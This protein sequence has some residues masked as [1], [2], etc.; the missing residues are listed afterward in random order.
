MCKCFLW[1]IKRVAQV[2]MQ[3][4]SLPTLSLYLPCTVIILRFILKAYDN[5]NLTT[6]IIA[7]G[8]MFVIFGLIC[9]LCSF[10]DNP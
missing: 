9:G 5:R 4:L 2:Y 10:I 3:F 1:L 7:C 6:G 8:R